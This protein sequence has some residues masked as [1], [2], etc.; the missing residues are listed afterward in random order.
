M[1]L[2]DCN[3]VIINLMDMRYKR[4]FRTTIEDMLS[5]LS[6]DN[7]DLS[8][9]E[10]L[11]V[12]LKDHNYS[13]DQL[14]RLYSIFKKTPRKV[15]FKK[16]GK[17]YSELAFVWFENR[18]IHQAYKIIESSTHSIIYY[19]PVFSVWGSSMS[20]ESY[21]VEKNKIIIKIALLG[22]YVWKYRRKG[23]EYLPGIDLS[24]D[25]AS[26]AL[27]LEMGE[28]RTP[29]ESIRMALRNGRYVTGK[30]PA[31]D[32][33]FCA[34]KTTGYDIIPEVWAKVQS[35]FEPDESILHGDINAAMKLIYKRADRLMQYLNKH[36]IEPK[37]DSLTY[38]VGGSSGCY[39]SNV[40][41]FDGDLSLLSVALNDK[42]VMDYLADKGYDGLH[43]YLTMRGID[44]RLDR[45]WSELNDNQKEM[46]SIMFPTPLVPKTKSGIIS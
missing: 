11:G 34:S 26:D 4:L 9:P 3:K 20:E 36:H 41:A 6:K 15:V 12:Y 7:S 28:T 39:S 35:E 31:L 5:G 44:V 21:Y 33:M 40:G 13:H 30:N 1:T 23:E 42:G 38:L 25:A 10:L 37:D 27:G 43:D 16:R 14:V 24:V 8:G 32:K 29:E 45:R 18:L 17:L 22:A 46:L 19:D 2:I